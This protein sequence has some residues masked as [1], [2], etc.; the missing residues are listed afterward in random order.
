MWRLSVLSKR[1]RLCNKS[2]PI[3]TGRRT[4]RGEWVKVIIHIGQAKTGTTSLQSAFSASRAAL[5]AQGFLY[6]DCRGE[7]NHGLLTVPLMT[8]PQR[9][10]RARVGTDPEAARAYSLQVWSELSDQI[11][12]AAAETA[13]ETV[14]LSSEFFWR[15][16]FVDKLRP[17]IAR[18]VA[19]ETELEFLA[20]IRRPS[21]HYVSL[22]QQTLK[23]NHILPPLARLDR[24]MFTKFSGIGPLTIRGFDRQSLI[25]GD[26]VADAAAV[27]G[28]DDRRLTRPEAEANTTISAEAMVLLQEHRQRDHPER[29]NVFTPDTKRLL[30]AI[31]A[32]EA[33]HPGVFTRPR[34]R[35][36]LARWLDY[37]TGD[38]LWIR[39]TFGVDLSC[40]PGN[41]PPGDGA[42]A[43]E[44]V[45][46]I[47]DHDP[48]ALAFLRER[49]ARR[50]DSQTRLSPAGARQGSG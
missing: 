15:A 48:Q 33:N 23:A 46:D 36:E 13:I 2:R 43:V 12:G 38:L 28:I 30:R 31:R 9:S 17:L 24:A 39:D 14:I 29:R 44:R 7:P 20:Y 5:R 18:F 21:E 4:Q 3:G 10:L 11:A 50:L 35:P 8:Q 1:R 26:I 37:P 25:G 22:A 42:P 16:Q 47:V 45:A 32:V 19:A 40:D 41:E 27:L 49:V 6:P 34:L